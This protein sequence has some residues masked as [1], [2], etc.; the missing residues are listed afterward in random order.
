M[1]RPF[2]EN[3]ALLDHKSWIQVV[4]PTSVPLAAHLLKCPL[5][6]LETPSSC[7]FIGPHTQVALLC[8]S[9]HLLPSLIQQDN[10]SLLNNLKCPIALNGRQPCVY[11]QACAPIQLSIAKV[12]M[13]MLCSQLQMGLHYRVPTLL[14][15]S[16]KLIFS[17]RFS[18]LFQFL[19]THST[20]FRAF[21]LI[22]LE[23]EKL[24]HWSLSLPY[25]Q[26]FWPKDIYVHHCLIRME[27]ESLLLSGPHL[28]SKSCLLYLFHLSAT[29][30]F[31]I[32][33]NLVSIHRLLYSLKENRL[34]ASSYW[35][36]LCSPHRSKDSPPSLQFS[37]P[38][39]PT[40]FS[41]WLGKDWTEASNALNC[42]PN[43][44]MLFPALNLFH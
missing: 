2:I 18:H 42:S 5:E 31:L 22:S 7:Q 6:N 35:P 33:A 44:W 32:T 10:H 27:L 3:T 8:I 40:T 16:S 17:P 21:P 39:P 23:I 11:L 9:P 15:F 26:N 38:R 34:L 25:H 24:W 30:C 1:L 36:F 14:L 19:Q 13:Q 4:N 43:L 28:S 41:V 29:L 12:T 37:L 20:P